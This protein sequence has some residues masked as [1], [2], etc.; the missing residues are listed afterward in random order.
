MHCLLSVSSSLVKDNLQ[1]SITQ[2]QFVGIIFLGFALFQCFNLDVAQRVVGVFLA[3]GSLY[4][5][6]FSDFLFGFP[7]I[8]IHPQLPSFHR[9]HSRMHSTKIHP[10]TSPVCPHPNVHQRN[11]DTQNHISLAH[12]FLL[13][14]W[15]SCH[16]FQTDIKFLVSE[17]S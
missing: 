6:S 2:R 1:F 5:Q 13:M 3:N 7:W 8:E 10:S 11:D 14:Y 9:N 17:N 15:A 12:V 16:H 4:R